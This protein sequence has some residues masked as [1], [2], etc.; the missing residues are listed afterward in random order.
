[1]DP[2]MFRRSMRRK[3]TKL[4]ASTSARLGQYRIRESDSGPSSSAPAARVTVIVPVFNS[5]PYLKELLD[6]LAAQDMNPDLFE[7]I[8]IDDGS[9]D[10]SGKL[11][12]SYATQV[13][14]C[15]VIHQR[16]SGWPGKPRNVGIAASRSDYVFFCDSDD[17]MGPEALRRMVDFADAH[18]VDVLAPKLVGIGGRR[19]SVALFGDTLID[20]PL[21]TI[22]GTLSPQKMIRRSLLEEHTIRFPEGKVRLEDGMMLTRCY[23]F[24]SRNSIL[25]D[26]DYYF[27]RTRQVGCN[28]SSGRAQPEG[29]TASVAE[30]ARTIKKLHPKP[31]LADQ[32]VLDLYR[33]KA[34]RFYVPARYRAMSIDQRRRWVKAHAQFIR[35]YIP[36]NLEADLGFPFLQ[37][38]R[39][40][41][42]EDVKGLLR[43]ATTEELLTATCR[44]TPPHPNGGQ[45]RF[46]LLPITDFETVRLFVQGR[47]TELKHSHIL[48]HDGHEYVLD[49]PAQKFE[50][51]DNIVADLFI[52]ME[53]AGVQGLMRRV[54]APKT[55]MPVDLNGTRLYATVNGYLSIDRRH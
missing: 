55:G 14:N 54:A 27:I 11:L 42:A 29:Y 20:A 36:E 4:T 46:E 22:F 43:F 25:A 18:Q 23:L 21:R 13:S 34:L 15:R 45:L 31:A 41:R 50:S 48:R 9:T 38:S 51:L 16:N 52:Q 26:Y 53:I 5:M 47:G 1:M 37:R 35:E 19:V 7:V 3:L 10:G 32:L 6:S 8:A 40:I 24:S 17:L 49:D 2:S 28:I 33:R 39:L 30:I 44:A 12:D